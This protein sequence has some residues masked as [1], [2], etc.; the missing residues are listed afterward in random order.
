MRF[1]FRLRHLLVLTV[2]VA[3]FT[4]KYKFAQ[5]EIQI[6]WNEHSTVSSVL[7]IPCYLRVDMRRRHSR[8]TRCY[9]GLFGI[10]F[11]HNDAVELSLEVIGGQQSGRLSETSPPSVKWIQLSTCAPMTTA[12]T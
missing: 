6:Y 4:L 9:Y 10:Y 11:L 1:Q 12:A 5:E 3:N 7:W 8:R 2:L